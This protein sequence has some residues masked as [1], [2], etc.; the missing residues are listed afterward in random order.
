MKPA[1]TI[2][3]LAWNEEDVIAQTIRSLA[4]QSVWSSLFSVN[5]ILYCNG[6]TDRTAEVAREAF[7]SSMPD[8][9]DAI[10]IV[11]TQIA[12]KSR[13]W[14]AVVHDVSD[15]ATDYF[16]FLDA[17][18]VFASD[19]ACLSILTLLQED[20]HCVAVSGHP[21]KS[22]AL[23]QKK[24]IL[25][26]LSLRVSEQNRARA[27]NG[28]LYCITAQ[29]ARRIVLP[30][31][32]SG[33]DGFLNAMVHTNGFAGTPDDRRINQVDM[34]THYYEPATG[35]GIFHH[36]RR[37]TIGTIVNRWTFE[38]LWGLKSDVHLGSSIAD[39]NAND[40]AWVEK[41]VDRHVGGRRWVVPTG[42]LFWRM[43]DRRQMTAGQY[44]RR[45]PLALAATAFNITVCWA[46][47][48]RIR[49]GSAVGTW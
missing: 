15:P 17:D 1:V 34:A 11:D 41:I 40:P 28:S 46:A 13:A 20:P 7:A 4:G 12:G 39:W 47:N 31:K 35:L 5:L 32:S 10:R 25:D 16:L 33:E 22:F 49:A 42:M 14:N 8:A 45:L 43:P 36:E 30:T 18:I 29:E 38:H 26:R 23:K 44:L 27:I 6:C 3:M 21:V 37:V 2:V 24:T 9:L 19:D 48:R